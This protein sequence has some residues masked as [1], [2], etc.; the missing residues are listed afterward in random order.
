MR[1]TEIFYTEEPDGNEIRI[2]GFENVASRTEVQEE[3]G[4]A[5]Y[6]SYANS[7]PHYFFVKGAQMIV[8]VSDATSRIHIKVGSTWPR[9]IFGLIIS[10]LKNSGD[11]LQK[12]KQAR[13][14]N[15]III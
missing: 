7:Y 5:I 15:R 8:L 4:E 10:R 14:V 2:E 13:E 6:R 11:N 3:F 9:G 1:R 12:A